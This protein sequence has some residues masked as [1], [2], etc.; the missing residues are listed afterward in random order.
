M[1]YDWIPPRIG[2]ADDMHLTFTQEDF[3]VKLEKALT[4]LRTNKRKHEAEHSSP[5][6]NTNTG[7][8]FIDRLECSST[9]RGI[10]FV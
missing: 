3:L 2:P 4:N 6:P 7:I 5:R 10:P 8:N 1:G 9:R